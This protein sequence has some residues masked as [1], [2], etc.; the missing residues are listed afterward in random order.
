M[1]TALIPLALLLAG[2][3]TSTAHAEKADRDKPVHLESDRITVDDAKKIHVLEGNVQ[4]VQGTLMIHCDK[5]VVTQDAQGFQK[6]TATV[7][8][9]GLARFRQKREGKD[10]Y[11]DGEAERIVHDARSEKTEFF[12]RAYIKS[13]NDEVRGQYISYDGNNENYLVTSGANGTST[14][15]GTGKDSRVR[16]VIQPKP[17]TA[18]PSATPPATPAQPT[19]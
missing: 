18:T 12:Q 11:I 5:L 7:S 3:L 15:S 10:E 14:P 4:L 13:G 17:H 6:G 1:K 19:P 9:G 16:V 2:C 8:P